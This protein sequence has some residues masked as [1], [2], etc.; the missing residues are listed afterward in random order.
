MLQRKHF[1]AF[2]FLV[3]DEELFGDFEDLETGEVHLAEAKIDPER[4]GEASDEERGD[5]NEEN[6][7]EGGDNRLEKKK[8][9]K[10]AFNAVY[11]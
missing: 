7:T 9:K 4:E 1:C 10:A 3:S 2:E 5:E 11:P 6:E 8:Q